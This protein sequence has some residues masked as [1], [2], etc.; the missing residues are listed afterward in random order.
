M[1]EL[2]TRR[3]PFELMTYPGQRHGIQGEALQVHLMRTRLDFLKRHLK[4]PAE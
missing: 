2:Q 4:D 3:Q 1:A